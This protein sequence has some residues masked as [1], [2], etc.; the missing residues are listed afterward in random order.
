MPSKYAI[1]RQSAFSN[2]N[3]F[4]YY[5]NRPMWQK[6]PNK[7]SKKHL[8]SKKE[9]RIKEFVTEIMAKYPPMAE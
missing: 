3:G 4:C 8:I 1:A 7:F 9:A 2:Q 5:C 6:K